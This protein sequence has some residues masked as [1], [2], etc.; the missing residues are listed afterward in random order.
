MDETSMETMIA[1]ALAA[2]LAPLVSQIEA[3]KAQQAKSEMPPAEGTG[4]GAMAVEEPQLPAAHAP[5][6]EAASR[7]APPGKQN[8]SR[9][10]AEP[11][12]ASLDKG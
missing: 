4:A 1:R 7:P 3:V 2:A 5:G 8:Q 11:Y 6:A 12:D 10:D 9:V